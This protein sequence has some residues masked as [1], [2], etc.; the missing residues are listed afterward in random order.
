MVRKRPRSSYPPRR[1][2]VGQMHTYPPHLNPA[3]EELRHDR[4][5]YQQ[6]L[7]RHRGTDLE[8]DYREWLKQHHLKADLKDFEKYQYYL[9]HKNKHH[10]H[11]HH[12]HTHHP[13]D[14]QPWI[15]TLMQDLLSLI[16][17][18]LNGQNSGGYGSGNGS[19]TPG[20]YGGLDSTDPYGMQPDS[21]AQASQPQGSPVA[22]LLVAAGA[23]LGI[24]WYVRHN[25]KP[26][27]KQMKGTK[28]ELDTGVTS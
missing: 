16:P 5:Q 28:N 2:P 10:H 24:W 6:W 9:K 15:D 7:R 19:V 20:A 13:G 3:R 27:K 22:L 1:N 8:Q 26:K 25:E 12:T 14:Y 11:T 4:A 18:I 17:D 23:G 21:N